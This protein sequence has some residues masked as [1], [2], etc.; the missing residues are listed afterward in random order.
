MLQR[1]TLHAFSTD[2]RTICEP[3]LGEKW[4]YRTEQITENISGDSKPTTINRVFH[5]CEASAPAP[6]A[7][8]KMKNLAEESPLVTCRA[9]NERDSVSTMSHYLFLRQQRV[10]VPLVNVHLATGNL[11]YTLCPTGEVATAGVCAK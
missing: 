8:A 1:T 7:L 5:E 2:T 9:T 4:T 3:K 6:D 11:T 10:Y